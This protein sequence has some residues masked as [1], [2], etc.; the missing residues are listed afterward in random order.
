MYDWSE[1]RVNPDEVITFARDRDHLEIGEILVVKESWPLASRSDVEWNALRSCA[2]EFGV[3]EVVYR[4]IGKH[5]MSVACTQK[6]RVPQQIALREKGVRL[7]EAK[8]PRILLTAVL[9]AIIGMAQ[10]CSVTHLLI[11]PQ[12][13]WNLF[14]KGWLHRDVSIG[15]VLMLTANVTKLP[16]TG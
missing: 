9:H 7:V 3:A 10:I 12:G 8:S 13:H 6:P 5:P 14:R 2:K 15:N 1:L 4:V 11:P 16:P